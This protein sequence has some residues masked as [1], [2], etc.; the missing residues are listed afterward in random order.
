MISLLLGSFLSTAQAVPMQ[1]SQQGRL[2][3]SSGVAASGNHNL[4]FRLYNAS[5]GGTLLWNETVSSNFTNGYYSVVLGS[6]TINNPLEDSVLESGD[7]YV[8]I[9]IDSDGPLTP[10]SAI[11]STPFARVAGKAQV[12]DSADWSG[13]TSV[14]SDLSDGDDDTVGALSCGEG[15]QA[16]YTN[17]S[18]ACGNPVAD[19][20]ADNRL[21][22]LETLVASLQSDLATTQ[23]DLAT[24]QS[25]LAAAQSD[26]STANTTIASLESSL[27]GNTTDI[28]SNTSSINALETDLTAAEASIATLQTD[29]SGISDNVL[30]MISVDT[31][32]NIGSNGDYTDLADAMAAARSVRIHPDA[33]LT[34]Q[35]EDG[36]YSHTSGINLYHP[37]GRHLVIQGNTTDPEAVEL[38]FSGSNGLDIDKSG[39]V[40]QIQYLKI[41]GD[42]SGTYY[43]FYVTTHSSLWANDIIIDGF[44]G[45]GLMVQDASFAILGG[46]NTIQNTGYEGLFVQENSTFINHNGT[47]TVTGSG[48]DG[49][50]SQYGS[51]LNLQGLNI[52]NNAGPGIVTQFGSSTAIASSTIDSND[53]E[54][55]F[56]GYGS[57]A[58]ISH[59]DITNNGR[60]GL[61]A[62]G[63]TTVYVSGSTSN[64]SNNAGNGITNTRSSFVY[65]RDGISNNNTNVG[66]HSYYNSYGYKHA[67]ASA[68]GNDV[69]YTIGSDSY[70]NY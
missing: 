15:E 18:W 28:A 19:V 55:V 35:L 12:A 34:L 39:L 63:T 45:Y 7:L 36:V 27:A 65:F 3:D 2:V 70:G 10:R 52:S 69:N 50:Q 48:R 14:P 64:I 54:G 1:L 9:E 46:D 17:G 60:T 43:G 32:W 58:G 42:G 67:D 8:E 59:T 38:Y 31:T 5:T 47:L 23:S 68:S 6:D 29:V 40:G 61:T 66:F 13:L 26:L 4:T 37:D 57:A 62:Y 51:M 25:D 53:R 24:T 41:K 49:I 16:V 21:A 44:G 22:A 20:D 30:D 56:V 33:T 11:T